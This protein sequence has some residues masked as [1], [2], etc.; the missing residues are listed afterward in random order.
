MKRHGRW[1]CRAPLARTA[2]ARSS[3]SG[4][5]TATLTTEP[6]AVAADGSVVRVAVTLPEDELLA[7]AVRARGARQLQRPCLFIHLPPPPH[8]ASGT[9]RPGTA[10]GMAQP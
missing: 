5:V 8:R 10:P 3:S 1:S 6:S 7:A 4:R 2:A 9:S